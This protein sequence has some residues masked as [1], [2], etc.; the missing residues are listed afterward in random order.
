MAML[1]GLRG[2]N[3]HARVPSTVLFHPAPHKAGDCPSPPR[4]LSPASFLLSPGLTAP[5]PPGRTRTQ[6]PHNTLRTHRPVVG[7][8]PADRGYGACEI[9]AAST[10][11]VAPL[12]EPLLRVAPGLACV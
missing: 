6:L 2:R 4:E 12:P 11:Q 9:D 8:L 10:A 5:G 1:P 3:V 7:L